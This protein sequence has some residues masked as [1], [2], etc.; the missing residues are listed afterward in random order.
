MNLEDLANKLLLQCIPNMHFQN[1]S[2]MYDFI[3]WKEKNIDIDDDDDAF[4]VD[5]PS[6]P[7]PTDCLGA[8]IIFMKKMEEKNGI[9]Y[10]IF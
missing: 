5:T 3:A 8:S 10:S 9:K 6:S 7:K 2:Y 4:N 1:I